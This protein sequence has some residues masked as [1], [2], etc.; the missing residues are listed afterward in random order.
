[1][2]DQV[3]A[4]IAV[5]LFTLIWSDTP[6]IQLIYVIAIA[7]VIDWSQWEVLTGMMI[8]AQIGATIWKRTSRP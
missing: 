6:F 7:G 2:T 8:I 1:M 3:L 5:A 4:G